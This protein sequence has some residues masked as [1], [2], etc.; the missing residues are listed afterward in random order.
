MAAYNLR[1]LKY[2][3]AV[4]E[5]GSVAEASRKLYIAQPSVSTAI[6]QLEES[7]NVQL[8][9]RQHANGMSLTPAGTRFYRKAQELL[10]LAHEFEQ[11]ALADNDVVAG[12]VDIGCYETVAPLY[13]PMLIAGFGERW[14]GIEIRMRD[15]EQQELIQALTGGSIDL[16]ILFEHNLDNTIETA[17]LALP[18]QPY[19]LLPADHRYARQAKVSLEDLVL[20]PMIL[21]DTQPSR[22]YF[23]SI[24]TECGL[25][26]NITF[27]SPSIEMVRGMVAQGF[28]FSVLVTKPYSNYSYDGKEVACVP[29][30][31]TVTGS[32]LSA[33]WLRRAQLTRPAQLFVEHCINEFMKM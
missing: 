3:I 11:N 7:F 15:G 22:S 20:E 24:F 17:P 6:R 4:V 12:Q 32:G 25:T 28:G 18:R 29:L 9:I 27:S 19:A 2:F 26:P 33:A 16:A 13:L 1:Q 30:A 5:C 14:P 31:E 8:F 10:R 21:L 23:V